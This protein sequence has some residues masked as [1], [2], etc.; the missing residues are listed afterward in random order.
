LPSVV[1]LA[2]NMMAT[3][4]ELILRGANESRLRAL[5]ET[6]FDEIVSIEKRFSYYLPNSELSLLNRRAFEQPVSI[7]PD[8]LDLLLRAQEL[9]AATAGAFDPTIGPLVKCWAAGRTSVPETEEIAKATA[10]TGMRHVHIDP[11]AGTVA[12]AIN[13]LEIDLGG[14]AKG[15]AIEVAL[16]FIKAAGIKNILL[17]GGTSTVATLGT[18][19]DGLPWKIGISDQDNLLAT[20]ELETVSL[21]VSLSTAALVLGG[22]VRHSQHFVKDKQ[23]FAIWEPSEAS[24]KKR[25]G[26]PRLVFQE[27]MPAFL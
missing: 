17:H 5:G 1:R 22:E 25:P 19:F 18:S 16:E 12:Y 13:G 3:R 11:A 20:V 2:R 10:R 8:F 26:P 24:P 6:A 9:S 15:Y 23:G 4:F 21:S 14:I 27:N 7:A